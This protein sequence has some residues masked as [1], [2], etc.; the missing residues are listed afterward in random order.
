MDDYGGINEAQLLSTALTQIKTEHKQA[1]F[2]YLQNLAAH[3]E[4]SNEP[5]V[6]CAA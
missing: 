3:E 4:E 2:I 1:F 6:A 5:P